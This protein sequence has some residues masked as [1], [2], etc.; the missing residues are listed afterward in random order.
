MTSITLDEV[1]LYTFH[2]AV[3]MQALV[4][5]HTR[6]NSS[7]MKASGEMERNKVRDETLKDTPLIVAPE[8]TPR[9]ARHAMP[10]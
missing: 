9:T 1:L 10:H 3:C 2:V 6:T 7:D 5:T 4:S 8:P